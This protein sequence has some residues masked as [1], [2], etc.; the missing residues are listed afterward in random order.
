M[1]TRL[2]EDGTKLVAT[3]ELHPFDF[4]RSGRVQVW[5][6]LRML[7]FARIAAIQPLI[8]EHTGTQNDGSTAFVRYQEVEFSP[9]FYTIVKPNT[10]LVMAVGI[11]YVGRS[12]LIYDY[13]I[14]SNAS[15]DIIGRSFTQMVRVNRK[16]RRPIAW[17]DAL[18]DRFSNEGQDRPVV[19]GPFEQIPEPAFVCKVRVSNSDID[20]RKHTNQSVYLRYCLDAAAIA[21]R[22]NSFSVIKDIALC[23][24]RKVGILYQREALLGDELTLEM[25]EDQ[26][27]HLTPWVLALLIGYARLATLTEKS[28][29]LL[30]GYLKTI[31]SFL[32]YQE[33]HIQPGF[34]T[35]VR[36]D[37]TVVVTVGVGYVGKTSYELK[38]DVRLAGSAVLLCR[39]SVT[40]VVVDIT[41]RRP[42]ALPESLRQKATSPRPN[43]SLP[44]PSTLPSVHSQQFEV[45]ESHLD[46]N[47]HTNQSNYI[48]FCYN[49]AAF[50]TKAGRYHSLKGDLFSDY[51]VK[52]IAMLYQNEALLGDLLNVESWEIPKLVTL[53]FKVKRGEDEVVQGLFE[54]YGEQRAKL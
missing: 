35:D 12:S 31:T 41:T 13:G 32:R 22:R 54:L 49:A 17:P 34:Y 19:P 40:S 36:Q 51:R 20:V 23:P 24:I 2:S 30:P 38:G 9:R 21:A 10:S 11:S 37:S 29:F 43:P 33:F 25:W 53:G 16:T 47:G 18:I 15:D 3:Y 28:V 27:C 5:T 45:R 1:K 14:R 42:V 7:E 50:A 46:F 6:Y 8:K 39:F 44:F 4:D 52:K 26:G 48:M